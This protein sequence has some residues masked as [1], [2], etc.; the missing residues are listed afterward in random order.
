MV[1]V[2]VAE[3]SALLGGVEGRKEM[4]RQAYAGTERNEVKEKKHLGESATVPRHRFALVVL[5]TFLCKAKSEATTE[6]RANPNL[7]HVTFENH[8]A[9]LHDISSQDRSRT[10]GPFFLPF[11]ITHSLSTYPFFV[12]TDCTR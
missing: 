12:F 7:F 8:Y 3:G 4:V 10:L 5:F 1:H 9:K 11:I 6:S 2:G